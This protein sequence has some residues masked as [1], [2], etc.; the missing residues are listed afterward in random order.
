[1]SGGSDHGEETGSATGFATTRGA[2][3][4]PP[5]RTSGTMRPPPAETTGAGGGAVGAVVRPPP[6]AVHTIAIAELASASQSTRE[7]RRTQPLSARVPLYS[8]TSISS[9]S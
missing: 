9:P 1:M 8:T 6:Q 5:A 4:P 2:M 3:R 7:M